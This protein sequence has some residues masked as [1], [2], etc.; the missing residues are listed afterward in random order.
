[1]ENLGV[2]NTVRTSGHAEKFVSPS[3]SRMYEI[4]ISRFERDKSIYVCVEN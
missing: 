1:M 4:S 2:E 3:L